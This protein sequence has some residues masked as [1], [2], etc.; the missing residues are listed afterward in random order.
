MLKDLL[1]YRANPVRIGGILMILA[2]IGLG[3][4]YEINTSF[5]LNFWDKGYELKADFTDA[6]GIS[7]ASDV[8]IA[9]TYVGQITQ[10][11][12]VSGGLAE[13][14]I[15]L[16]KAHSPLPQGTTANLRLQTLLGTKFIELTPGPK[17]NQQL[18]ANSVIPTSSTQS[19]VDFDQ[20]LSSFDQKTRDDTGKIVREL[21]T[22]TDGQGSTINSLLVNLH[23]MSVNSTPSLQTFA[24]RQQ[25][26]N[27]ILVNL[28][29][30]GT[31]LANN[32]DHLAN[33]Y[34]QL[35][36][37]LATLA[38][39]DAGFRRF[40]EQG[41]VGLG[42]G[43]NQFDG[44]AQNINDIF[45]LLNPTLNKLNPVLV[46]VN[47]IAISSEPFIQIIKQFS[48]DIASA[49]SAYNSNNTNNGGAGGWYLRQ[50]VILHEDS[51]PTTDCE[52]SNP[53]AGCPS[54]AFNPNPGPS[55]AAAS[56]TAPSTTQNPAVKPSVVPPLPLPVPV[57]KVTPPALPGVPGVPAPTPGA[58]P[59]PPGVPGLTS[60]GAVPTVTGA[61]GLVGISDYSSSYGAFPELALFAYLLGAGG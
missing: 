25:N 58:L 9:G 15:R 33:V 38:A 51:G 17:N 23:G 28:D 36:E 14:T 29:N 44:Q 6:D 61:A 37:V 59:A 48:A 27:S 12:S 18:A 20:F 16:D 45:R 31:N 19:P 21:G 35:D 8:R 40:I 41:N 22:A 3:V 30:V 57:P 11:R 32:R 4:A 60:P 26:L 47:N 1:R 53:P 39:N 42:H 7:N 5:A 43:I 56:G 2:L 52:R 13:I 24:D 10:I 49:N 55:P 46:D 54:S 34:T 50:P